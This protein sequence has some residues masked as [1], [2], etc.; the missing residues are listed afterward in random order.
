MIQTTHKCPH[1]GSENIVKNGT[2]HSTGKQKYRCKDCK[3]YGAL[4]K[5]PRFTE[6]D[7][8]R[9]VKTYFERS[10]MH[11]MAHWRGE[12]IYFHSIYFITICRI[13]R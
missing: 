10:S 13:K 5:T 12:M 11:G 1:C 7:K 9:V 3:K 6:Q 2:C 4:V 8:Q